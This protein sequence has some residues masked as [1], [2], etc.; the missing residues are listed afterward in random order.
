[1][2]KIGKMFKSHFALLYFSRRTAHY[3]AEKFKYR[4]YVRMLEILC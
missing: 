3:H 4:P 2:Y 1:M